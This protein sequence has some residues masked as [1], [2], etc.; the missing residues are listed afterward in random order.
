MAGF[1]R[2]GS[3][4]REPQHGIAIDLIAISIVVLVN[5]SNCSTTIY[6]MQLQSHNCGHQADGILLP[7]MGNQRILVRKMSR[8]DD[9]AGKARS[10]GS[11]WETSGVSR[12]PIGSEK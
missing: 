5:S 2:I 10:S 8:V 12:H 1:G 9:D 6:G 7:R 4:L 3:L 11:L